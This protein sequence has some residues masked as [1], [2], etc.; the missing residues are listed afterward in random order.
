MILDRI[1]NA[2]LYAGLGAPIVAALEY[3]THLEPGSVMPGRH[4][5]GGGPRIAQTTRNTEDL[6]ALVSEYSTKPLAQGRWEAHRRYIDLHC[7][8]QGTE[9]IGYA[10]AELLRAE[11]YN[12][13]KDIMWLRGEGQFATLGP[14]DFMILFPHDAHMPGIA[15]DAPAPVKK[16]VVKIAVSGV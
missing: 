13:E 15:L 1:E 9:R 3:L 16:V 8:V 2:R 14:G 5:I 4:G 7:V 11:P 6:Y 12:E 10:P